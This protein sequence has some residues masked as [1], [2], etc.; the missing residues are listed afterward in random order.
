MSPASTPQYQEPA[1]A[2]PLVRWSGLTHLG[3]VRPNNEDAF[4]ALAIDGHEVRYLGKTGS[5]SLADQDFVFAVSD[6]MGGAKSGEFASRSTVAPILEVGVRISYRAPLLLCLATMVS[7]RPPSRR[8][9]VSVT[10][11]LLT[12]WR[13]VSI[14]TLDLGCTVNVEPSASLIVTK[15]PSS[16]VSLSPSI[17]RS[18]RASGRVPEATAPCEA[19]TSMGATS[20]RIADTG[21]LIGLPSGICR[22]LGTTLNLWKICQSLVLIR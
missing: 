1:P 6:G 17:T 5:A 8:S 19:I 14:R 15:L 3:R 21:I 13:A 4:L 20:E 11:P 9:T 7:R 2:A 18:P 10:P 16:V 22:G 12:S